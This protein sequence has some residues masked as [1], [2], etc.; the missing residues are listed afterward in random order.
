MASLGRQHRDRSVI[1]SSLSDPFRNFL[2]SRAWHRNLLA[3]RLSYGFRIDCARYLLYGQRP[4]RFPS[5]IVKT[6]VIHDQH[7]RLAESSSFNSTAWSTGVFSRFRTGAASVTFPPHGAQVRRRELPGD[8]RTSCKLR[9]WLP[10]ERGALAQI[11]IHRRPDD[12]DSPRGRQGTDCGLCQG[13]RCER[14]DAAPLAQA[15]RPV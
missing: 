9:G 7:A 13:A 4:R 8:F 10:T 11:P 12:Q 14:A 2:D 6:S 1:E 15:V 3:R 5:Q